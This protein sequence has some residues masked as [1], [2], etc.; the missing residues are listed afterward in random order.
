MMGMVT[1]E[2]NDLATESYFGSKS[3]VA[4]KKCL[5]I[6]KVVMGD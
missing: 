3:V 4:D 1:F 5:R 6:A 2:N